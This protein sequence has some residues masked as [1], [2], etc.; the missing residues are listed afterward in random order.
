MNISDHQ[1][2]VWKHFFLNFKYFQANKNQNKINKTTKMK[3]EHIMT[4]QYIQ[5]PIFISFFFSHIHLKYSKK[6]VRNH[7][8][9]ERCTEVLDFDIWTSI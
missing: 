1:Q 4:I 7:D 8:H 5:Q 3:Y 9:N 2:Q 6:Q